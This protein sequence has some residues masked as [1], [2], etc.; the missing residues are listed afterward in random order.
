VIGKIFNPILNI[1][2]YFEDGLCNNHLRRV[3]WNSSTFSLIIRCLSQLFKKLPTSNSIFN[4]RNSKDI[5]AKGS[6]FGIRNVVILTHESMEE[7][8]MGWEED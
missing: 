7:D 8:G 4:G 5:E 2:N 1:G 3:P 6:S